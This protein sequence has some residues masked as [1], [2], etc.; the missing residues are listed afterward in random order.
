MAV[1]TFTIQKSEHGLWRCTSPDDVGVHTVHTNP[2]MV[3]DAGMR[4][5]KDLAIE[6]RIDA[7]ADHE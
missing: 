6:R 4:M 3:L 2:M 7:D 1:K 5:A